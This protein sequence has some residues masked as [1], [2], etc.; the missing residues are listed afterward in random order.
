M[1]HVTKPMSDTYDKIRSILN[2]QDVCVLATAT[3]DKPYCSLMAFVAESDCRKIY[4]VTLKNTTKYGN[5]KDNPFVSLLMDDRNKSKDELL[6]HTQ[7]L[8]VNGK[9]NAIENIDVAMLP[10]G[11]T[12][13]MDAEEAA[14]AATGEE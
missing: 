6:P 10:I 8:T 13:T 7:A 11:G 3:Q 1:K 9:S 4:M 5:M 14:Q 2:G 12:Y